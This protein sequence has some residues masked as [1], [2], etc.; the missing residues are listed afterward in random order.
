MKRRHFKKISDR[1]FKRYESSKISA[2]KGAI[3]KILNKVAAHMKG[4]RHSPHA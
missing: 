2:F 4:L 1:P 3:R